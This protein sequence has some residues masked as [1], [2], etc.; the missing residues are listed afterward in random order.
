MKNTCYVGGA[1][2]LIGSEI[3]KLFHKEGHK[4]FGLDSQA[5]ES[6]FEIDLSDEKKV[7]SFFEKNFGPSGHSVLV[8]CQGIA[9]PHV[10]PLWELESKEWNKFLDVNLNS[11]FYTC[12]HFLKSFI[13]SKGKSASII[14]ISSTRHL[15]AEPNTEPYC[16]T[17]GA[18][19]SFTKALAISAGERGVRVNSISPGW[20]ASP[21]ADLREKDHAQHPAGRVGRPL[22][23]ARACL[24]LADPENSFITG[25]DLVIDGGMTAKMIYKD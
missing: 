23:I 9:D 15:M 2:G 6:V 1:A 10:G 7:S 19:N 17:K 13:N 11:Y 14:N 20:I 4:V 21:D 5:Q 18:I 8:N 25:Q 3:M 22:D 24:Y 16:A 12:K